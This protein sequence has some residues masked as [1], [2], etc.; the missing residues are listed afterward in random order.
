MTD[1]AN[2]IEEKRDGVGTIDEK[3]N[4]VDLVEE[5]M[6]NPG[7]TEQ[8]ADSAILNGETKAD[9]LRHPLGI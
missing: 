5:K 9:N 8:M 3:W 1:G 6:V 7:I 2:S 4:S